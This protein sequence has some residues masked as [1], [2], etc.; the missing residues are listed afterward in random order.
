MTKLALFGGKPVIKDPLVKYNSIGKDEIAQVNQVLNSGNLSG[1]YG[2]AREEFYGGTKV[3]E[4]EDNW[5]EKFKVN[6]AISVNSNTTGLI[7]AL[8]AIGISPGDEVIV[9]PYTM[10]ATA[11]CPLI[12][13]GIPVFVDIDDKT[14]CLDPVLVE[15]SITEKTKAIIV[16]NLFGHPAKL[17]EL[18]DIAKKYNLFLIEDNAQAP[19]ASEGGHLTGTVGHI[20]VFSLNYHK[21]IHTGE[22]GICVTNDEVLAEKMALIRNHAENVTEPFGISDISNLIGFNFRLTEMSAAVGI[23]QL[24]KIDKHV[25]AR[26]SAAN[27]LTSKLK[28]IPGITVP[29]VRSGCRHVYYLWSFLFDSD[30]WGCSRALFLKAFSEEG[31]SLIEGYVSPL[32]LLPTFQKRIAIG[33]D[34]FPFN[35]TKRKYKQGLC[36]I[37]EKMHYQQL[38]S[39][40]VCDYEFDKKLIDSIVEIFNKLYDARRLLS[41]LESNHDK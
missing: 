13:G 34:G 9:P 2:S 21:H 40:T 10:S 24:N 41:K 4:F 17:K 37:T 39:L 23:A 25:S 5:K 32:Y 27:E 3:K 12:Y 18:A 26:E 28:N 15:K 36:P 14:F 6:Y 22:G 7:A 33:R 1:F 11:I 29:Y 8:G 35:L 38:V 30:V 19:L 31:L 20:G 16:V